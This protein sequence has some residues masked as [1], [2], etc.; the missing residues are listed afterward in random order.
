MRKIAI[1]SIAVAALSVAVVAPSYAQTPTAVTE[2]TAN[3]K[4]S[5]SK[6]GT[7]KKPQSVKL[8]LN[9]TWKTSGPDGENKP[10]VQKVKIDF[11]KGSL[12]LGGSYKAKC[13]ESELGRARL[14][15]SDR[16]TGKCAKAVVGSGTGSAWAD[17]VKTTPK[18]QLVNGGAKNV[19]LYTV[20]KN[21]ARVTT[22]VPGVIKKGG[23]YGGYE[24]TLTVPQEL[25]VVAGTPISLISVNIKTTA[26]NWIAT[27][28]CP[29][30]K[31][32]P[33]RVTS[34][35]D[36]TADAVFESFVKCS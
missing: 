24:L 36:T 18:F 3:P 33:F 27:T 35:Q 21:P 30:N 34:S 25:Q 1:P 32:W 20:L 16:L 5:P 9:G 8:N 13:S 15:S 17:T 10:V 23:K 14:D 7:K 29:A 22:P 31:K 19:Y 12:Y 4:V 11:P 2:I 28:S 6:A 26:K